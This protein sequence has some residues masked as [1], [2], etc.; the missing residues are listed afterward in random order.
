[1]NMAEYKQVMDQVSNDFQAIIKKQ[2]EMS[3][4][5]AALKKSVAD[6]QERSATGSAG[7]V[8][9]SEGMKGMIDYIAGRKAAPASVGNPASGGYLAIPDFQA[10]VVAKMYDDSPILNE[11]ETIAV[12]GNLAYLPYEAAAP[13]AEWLGEGEKSSN[14]GASLGVAQIPVNNL[15][16]KVPI[17]NDLIQDSN[18]VSVETYLINSTSRSMARSIGKA[19]ISGTGVKSPQGVTNAK[20]VRKIKSG[21]SKGITADAIFD[22][23]AALPDEADPGAIWAMRK[24]TFFAI[25][26]QFGKDSTY[27]NM[28]MSEAIQPMILGHKVV[29]CADYA[30]L[31]TD[32]KVCATF[33]NFREGYKAVQ[34]GGMTYQRDEYSASDED[35]TVLRF[36]QRIGGQVVIPDAFVNVQVGA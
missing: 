3:A 36:K 8:H 26:K 18:L 6:F 33:G 29:F 30:G 1:M 17:S 15:R 14:A 11:V 31:D 24:D 23:T 34:A 27:V 5:Y 9:V 21:A 10:R 28:P 4:D 19:I 20:T 35:Q 25:A 16:A 22:I 32:G 7:Q 2:Q 13:E 12:D